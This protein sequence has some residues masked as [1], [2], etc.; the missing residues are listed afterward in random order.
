MQRVGGG[1][2]VHGGT[3]GRDCA[4]LL[5]AIASPLSREFEDEVASHR[6]SD[7]RE[8]GDAVALEDA[9]NHGRHVARQTRVVEGGREVIHAAAVA[10]VH[11]DDVHA[12]RE[13]IAGYTQHVL[14]V[15]GAF[16]A[17]DD[18]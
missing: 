13:P 14:R 1:C 3:D 6:E 17:V 7:Q 9:A 12:G 18:D 16:E 4:K 11:E 10:L 15:R 5:R 8:A 2:E